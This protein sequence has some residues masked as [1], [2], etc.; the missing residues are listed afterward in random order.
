LFASL[1]PGCKN[2]QA[3][4]EQKPP[5]PVHVE[6]QAAVLIEA[7]QILRLTGTLRGARE[8][9]L[10][11]NVAGRVTRTLVERGS[12]VKAGD[13]LA[14]VDVRAAALSLAEARVAVQTSQTQQAINQADCDRYEQLRAR[15]AV[16][17]LEYDQ[18]TASARRLHSIWRPPEHAKAWPPRTWVTA[19][20]APRSPA[21]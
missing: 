18:V 14:Q 21:L 1:L 3:Q 20:S 17:A 4:P 7:P 5:A 13:V 15:D 11:A 16:T 6:T 10:A 8:T 19:S 2:K 9:D 12:E